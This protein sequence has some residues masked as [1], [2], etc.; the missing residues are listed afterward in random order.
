[1]IY[2]AFKTYAEEPKN[3]GFP[4]SYP[5]TCFEV[6]TEEEAQT[7]YPG[8]HVMDKASF[9]AYL[10]GLRLTCKDQIAQ[11]QATAMASPAAWWEFWK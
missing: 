4:D 1:M 11:A 10:A 9:E 3:P 5:S 8:L 6:N 2:V 7:G